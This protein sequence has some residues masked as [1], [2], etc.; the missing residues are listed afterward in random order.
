MSSVIKTLLALSLSGSLMAALLFTVKR[1]LS[2]RVSRRFWYYIWLPVLIRMCLPVAGMFDLSAIGKTASPPAAS[3]PEASVVEQVNTPQ[4]PSQN[5]QGLATPSLITSDPEPAAPEAVRPAADIWASIVRTAKRPSTQVYIWLLGAGVML[6]ANVGS[7]LVFL[8]KLNSR[9]GEPDET[10]EAAF[11]SLYGGRRVKLRY[12]PGVSTPMLVGIIRPSIVL[13]EKS[14]PSPDMENIL[15]HELSHYRRGDLYFKWFA[16]AVNCVHWFNP[17]AHVICHEINRACEPAC[18]EAVIAEMTES[19]RRD[20]GETLLNLAASHR[21]P[22]GILATS[23]CEE[24]ARLKERI[25]N[26]MSYKK[27]AAS[28]VALSLVLAI[29]LCGCGSV[30]GTDTVKNPGASVSSGASVSEGQELT[31][32]TQDEISWFNDEFFNGEYINMH[33]QFLSSVYDKPQDIDLFELFYCGTPDNQN[34]FPSQEEKDKVV[35]AASMISE[36]DC[37]C[38]KNTTA[39]MNAVLQEYMGITLDETN[40]VGLDKFTYLS[41]YDAYYYFHG[42]TN[43]VLQYTMD[44]GFRAKNG[45]VYLYYKAL[46]W[47]ESDRELLLKKNGDGYLFYS[48][49]DLNGTPELPA[50]PEVSNISADYPVTCSADDSIGVGVNL[51][52]NGKD[53]I[54][55]YGYFGLFS[56]DLNTKTIS[57]SADLL[58]TLGVN[59]IQGDEAVCADVSPD[60]YTVLLYTVENGQP[61]GTAYTICCDGS[62]TTADYA[63][64]AQ[65]NWS[66]PTD[67]YVSEAEGDFTSA[68]DTIGS[69]VFTRDGQ[70]WNV[71]DGFFNK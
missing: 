71:F 49:I 28:A 27:T 39:D 55:F 9:L 26:I 36:P 53:H 47:Y 57:F 44:S 25:V 52:Y 23:M 18:D 8:R 58:S 4:A 60:G 62:Y 5:T 14:Y 1:L 43:Y 37:M 69:L 45:D 30:L 31:P 40:K 38:Q 70:T 51:V 19:Q 63:P 16:M 61:T 48:N 20:Y 2:G 6:A 42:D 11:R 21:L 50:A 66:T 13:P 46:T 29:L 22:A 68:D 65:D 41:E 59:N 7:Y 24:K 10:A 15:R 67:I 64:L 56:Y 32:L 33:N 3:R 12:C 54:V 35:A 17:M 34:S